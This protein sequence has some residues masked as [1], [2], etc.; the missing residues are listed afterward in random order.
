MAQAILDDKN[1]YTPTQGILPL[2]EAISQRW[3]QGKVTIE[4][5]DIIVSAG[6]ASLLYL[7][8]NA[9]F[10]E[11]DQ[12]VLIDP[13]FVIYESLSHLH[14]LQPHYL[15]EDFSEAEVEELLG[16]PGFQPK[17]VIFATPSNPTGRIL[18][19]EQISL[20]AKISEKTGALLISDEIYSAFDYDAKFFHTAELLPEKTITLSGFSKSHAMTGLRVGYMG[21]PPQL[22]GVL[23]KTAALQQYSIV[24]SPQPAQWAA[25]KA[26]DTPITEE[27]ALMKRRRDLVVDKLKGRVEIGSPDGA[28][29]L[30]PEIPL[31]GTEFVKRAIE[32]ELLVVPGYIFSKNKNTVRISYAQKEEELERGLDIFLDLLD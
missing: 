29:Y 4:P 8:Y 32:R 26:L 23:E 1:A 16:R 7:L 27:L 14:N 19:R 28:F 17:A 5:Q 20:L 11:G 18:T 13:Y 24:C 6:V 25:L 22:R 9:I 15:P 12:V 31:D 21:V 3:A 10:D 2:R 30:F